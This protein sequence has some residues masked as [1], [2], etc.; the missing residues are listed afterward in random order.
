MLKENLSKEQWAIS[1][2][3]RKVRFNDYPFREYTKA[4]GSGQTQTG[5]AAG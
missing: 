5:K 4:G 2:Q 3:D 1:S